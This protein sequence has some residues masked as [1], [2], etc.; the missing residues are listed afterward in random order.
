MTDATDILDFWFADGPATFRQA[1]FTKD[2]E[3]DAEIAGRFGPMVVPARDGAFDSW[4]G[5]PQGTPHGALALLL[6]L[7]QF[8]RNLHRGS[9]E[10]FASDDHARHIA[11]RAVLHDGFDRALTPVERLFLYLPFEHGEALADQDLSVALFEGLRDIPAMTT[12][13]GVIDYAWRHR[14]VIISFGRFPHR[15]D[16]LGRASTSGEIAWL[17]AGG[18][19]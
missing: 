3:F 15:N 18:G 6:L 14:T 7:D 5:T 10:A 16:A 12:P 13:A 8:P 4:A 11:R 2:P 19:F 9:A 17:A 1:W